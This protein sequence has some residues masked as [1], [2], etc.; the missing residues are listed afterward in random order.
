MEIKMNIRNHIF[1][2]RRIELITKKIQNGLLVENRRLLNEENK[3][4]N[5]PK[6]KRK[7][8]KKEQDFIDGLKQAL[9]EVKLH[10]EGK[11]ELQSLQEFL[12]ELRTEN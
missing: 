7:F 6:P 4:K 1:K 8:T 2:R 12:E 9:I 3:K 5:K 10:Q 11:I